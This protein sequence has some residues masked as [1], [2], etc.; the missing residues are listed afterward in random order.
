MQLDNDAARLV[1]AI[2]IGDVDAVKGG[3]SELSRKKKGGRALQLTSA[4]LHEKRHFLDFVSTNYGAF[5]V[6]QFLEIYANLPT[7]INAGRKV[8]QLFLPIEVYLDPVRRK[9]LGVESPPSEVIQIAGALSKKRKMVEIDRRVFS[10]RLGNFEIGGEAQLEA[11][12]YSAQSRFVAHFGGLEA[13]ESFTDYVYDRKQFQDKYSAFVTMGVSVGLIPLRHLE[14]LEDRSDEITHRAHLDLALVECAIFASL[15]SNYV[16]DPARNKE[17]MITSSYPADRFAALATHLSQE[18]K[19][20]CEKA[21]GLNW[22]ECWEVVNKSCEL[23]FGQRVESQIEADIEHTAGMLRQLR[24]TENET[25]IGF[26]D[27]F[28]SLR[29]QSLD[30][31]RTSPDRIASTEQFA[32]SCGRDV[33]PAVVLVSSNGELND[34]PSHLK[35][36]MSYDTTD[37]VDGD[38][39]WRKWWWAAAVDFDVEKR[40]QD[41]LRMSRKENT[42]SIID[43]HAPLAKLFLNGR[44]VRTIVG[45]ELLFV[46]QRVR[47]SFGV[48]FGYYPGFAYPDDEIP[49]SV[50]RFI[51]LG[52]ELVCDYS[53][54]IIPDG[55]ATILTPWALRRYPDLAAFTIENLGGH[56]IAYHAFVKDWTHWAVSKPVMDQLRK[57]M[58]REYRFGGLEEKPMLREGE[59]EPDISQIKIVKKTN[60]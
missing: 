21:D 33:S 4:F 54:N 58:V 46:E 55:E 39:P 29:R 36:L 13:H 15:Q 37:E 16:T 42:F 26:A 24:T 51:S 50:L 17:G 32:V 49:E 40:N 48:K 23:I 10:S 43:F 38:C 56:D 30:R 1:D 28:L 35:K 11:L 41:S 9:V 8:D 60:F 19:S 59:V 34:A 5:R 52:N 22:S 18:H 25:L 12:A 57:L 47:Q 53:N 27:D 7:L 45:P 31:L 3:F 14:A 6:R 44:K 20:L 2:I